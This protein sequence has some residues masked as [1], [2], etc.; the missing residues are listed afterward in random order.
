MRTSSWRPVVLA[1]V[2]SLSLS[3][4]AAAADADLRLLNAMK[5]QNEQ[6]ARALLKAAVNVNA[7]RADG[8]TAFYWPVH[9]S[10]A[11]MVDLLPK[12]GAKINAVDDHGVSP[13]KLACENADAAIVD[14]LLTAG[15]D[16]KH[17]EANGETALMTAALSGNVE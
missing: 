16:A 13:L 14:R 5:D 10:D 3:Q 1:L 4:V 8:A 7:A 9:W 2:S 15:A 17:A 6:A 12:A 11:A